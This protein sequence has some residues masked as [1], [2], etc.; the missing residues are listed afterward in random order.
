MGITQKV[1]HRLVRV[2]AR[3]LGSPW[4]D[5]PPL[6]HYVL[7]PKT[8]ISQP[9]LDRL[10]WDRRVLGLMLPDDLRDIAWKRWVERFPIIVKFASP[11][12]HSFGFGLDLFNAVHPK[13]EGLLDVVARAAVAEM[14]KA[15]SQVDAGS[16]HDLWTGVDLPQEPP[17]IWRDWSAKRTAFLER[18]RALGL[19]GT[20][21][22]D[23]IVPD[24][25]DFVP[26]TALREDPEHRAMLFHLDYGLHRPIPTPRNL[27]N[28]LVP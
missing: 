21:G 11:F 12:D 27:G 15:I 10:V 5:G 17:F 22:V 13:V 2:E 6:C 7:A 1:L 3:F 8:Q 20:N 19:L 26:G 25:T 14:T 9:S 4:A 24:F 16:L 18:A 28:P 23:D